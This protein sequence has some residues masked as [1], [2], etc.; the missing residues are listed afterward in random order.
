[1]QEQPFDLESFT[2]EA[3]QRLRNGEELSGKDGILYELN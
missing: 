2:Q 3:A 1:M